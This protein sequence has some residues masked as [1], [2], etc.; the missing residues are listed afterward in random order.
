MPRGLMPT[1]MAPIVPAE[2][3]SLERSPAAGEQL[4]HHRVPARLR[5]V[6]AKI[7]VVHDE[8]V[9]ARQPEPL[10]TVLE[11]APDAVGGVVEDDLERTATRLIRAQDASDFRRDHELRTRLLAQQST[12]AQLAQAAAVP[13]R[14]IV[15]ANASVPGGIERRRR[16]RFANARDR[17]AAKAELVQLDAVRPRRRRV[18]TVTLPLPNAN[19]T[20]TLRRARAASSRP[21][22]RMVRAPPSVAITPWRRSTSLCTVCPTRRPATLRCA[23]GRISRSCSSVASACSP[24][25]HSSQMR[26]NARGWLGQGIVPTDPRR[27]SSSRNVPPAPPKMVTRSAARRHRRLATCAGCGGLSIFA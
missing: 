9:H 13:R 26:T 1:P 16:L 25:C 7:E 6:V 21:A 12:D 2:R 19:P 11:R 18:S 22:G 27:N 3:R 24:S 4:T 17:G 15:I 23:N 10:Q 5:R 14:G 8:H 20:R